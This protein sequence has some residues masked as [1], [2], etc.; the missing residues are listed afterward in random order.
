MEN[1]TPHSKTSYNVNS[2]SKCPF[3]GGAIKKGA[4]NVDL[5]YINPRFEITI[6]G[7]EQ[8]IRRQQL[9][10][11]NLTCGIGVRF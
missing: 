5:R 1:N 10:T 7:G 6:T 9:S 11:L 3:S 8:E 2:E 4:S